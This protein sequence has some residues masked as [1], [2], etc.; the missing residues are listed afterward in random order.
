MA[1]E[2]YLFFDGNCR[3]ALALY[4]QAFQTEPTMVMTYGQ[5]PDGEVAEADRERIL[6][7]ALPL[8]GTNLMM[9]DCA[10]GTPYQVGNNISLSLELATKAEI[11]RLFAVLSP[12]GEVMQAPGPQFFSPWYTMFSDQFGVWWQLSL[13]D[14]L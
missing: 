5:T 6:Y 10:A 12:G 3:Q 9:S 7:S 8:D 11:D 1:I 14:A 4:A 2:A 13:P